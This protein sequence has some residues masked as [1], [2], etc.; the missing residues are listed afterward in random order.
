MVSFRL[1]DKDRGGGQGEDLP[2]GGKLEATRRSGG[3]EAAGGVAAVDE[4][5]GRR[6]GTFEVSQDNLEASSEAAAWKQVVHGVD[7]RA[8]RNMKKLDRNT[9]AVFNRR[10][11]V[12]LVADAGHR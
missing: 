1:Y 7:E 12:L 3:G 2:L 8:V 9:P 4:H 10:R 6:V 11:G 5:R